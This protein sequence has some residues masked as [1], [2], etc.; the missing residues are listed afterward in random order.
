MYHSDLSQSFITVITSCSVTIMH[1]QSPCW[2]ERS[3]RAAPPDRPSIWIGSSGTLQLQLEHAI[4]VEAAF[5]LA[6]VSHSHCLDGARALP[7]VQVP[8]EP[9]KRQPWVGA[10]NRFCS[11]CEFPTVLVIGR[12]ITAV[13]CS[14]G[15]KGVAS[16]SGSTLP[17]P[18][19]RGG[20]GCTGCRQLLPGHRLCSSKSVKV[21]KREN[22]RSSSTSG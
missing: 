6:P 7:E 4:A 18:G 3:S 9:T 10:G 13:K 1:G 12:K 15:A 11:V 8:L 2:H 5:S 14:G 20:S 21:R 22:L 19:A 16:K 17:L